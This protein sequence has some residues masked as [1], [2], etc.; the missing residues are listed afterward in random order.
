MIFYGYLTSILYAL[1]CIGAGLVLYKLGVPKKFTRKLVH[2]L[3]GFEWVI[4]YHFMGT[5]VHFLVVCLLFLGLL[6][7]DY[8]IKLVP[9]MSSDGENAPGTV[10]YAVAMSVMAFVTLFLPEMVIPFGVGVFATS[11]GDGLAGVGGQAAP[12]HNPKIYGKKSLLGTLTNAVV[13]FV[14]VVAFSEIFSLG[15]FL[16]QSLLIALFAV[17]LELVVGFGLDNIAITVGVSALTYA[18]IYLP[19]VTNYIAPILVTPLIIALAYKKRSLTLGGVLAAVAVDL[20]ISVP[21]GNFGFTTLM[22]FFVGSVAVDKFKKWYKSRKNK[23]EIDREKRGD[24][25]DVVQVLA[26]GLV[27]SLSAVL[28]FC[29]GHRVFVIAFVASLAEAFAD[30]VASGVGIVARRVY[31]IFRFERC[32]QG[33]SGGMSLPGT[34]ASLLASAA[35]SLV[36]YAFGAISIL[37]LLIITAAAFLGAIFDSFLGSLLQVKYKCTVCSEIVEKE[38]HCGAKTAHYRGVKIINNDVV[39]L[40]STAASALAAAIVFILI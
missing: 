37:E 38:E 7:L 28:Y 15:L 12:R 4:L 35:V 34:L 10:Y 32:E 14:T 11:F 26:N 8:K 25:R 33:I 18:F 1:L 5:S 21:L 22:T 6:A 24:C 19:E 13:C 16:W 20:C 31:D 36:A 40:L 30:T 23:A 17:I 29:L 39:N 27:A 9:A 3:V 2:I